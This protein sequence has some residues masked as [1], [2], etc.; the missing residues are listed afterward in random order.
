MCIVPCVRPGVSVGERPWCHGGHPVPGERVS[1]S[2]PP[3]AMERGLYGELSLQPVALL[4]PCVLQY[5]NLAT[6][7][8]HIQ[9]SFAL[10]YLSDDGG[11]HT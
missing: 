10:L 3:A 2:I 9:I 1:L 7:L 4:A 8:T 5:P 11:T 6:C